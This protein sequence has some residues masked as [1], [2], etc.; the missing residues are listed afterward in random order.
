MC[1]ETELLTAI[2]LCLDFCVFKCLPPLALFFS[3]FF[4]SALAVF[5]NFRYTQNTVPLIGTVPGRGMVQA[6]PVYRFVLLYRYRSRN[7]ILHANKIRL[8]MVLW[9]RYSYGFGLFKICLLSL[10]KM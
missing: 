2:A 4:C 3:L 6:P 5:C 9:V 8:K 1:A 7:F 10:L